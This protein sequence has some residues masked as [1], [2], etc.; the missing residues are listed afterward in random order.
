MVYDKNF[1]V[2]IDFAH[3]P[4]AISKFLPEI[5]KLTKS[6]LIHVFGSAGERDKKKRPEMGKTSAEHAD[7]IIVGNSGKPVFQKFFVGSVSEKLISE[8]PCSVLVAK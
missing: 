4:N 5:K 2:I 1:K 3:T 6:R 7:I 8:S